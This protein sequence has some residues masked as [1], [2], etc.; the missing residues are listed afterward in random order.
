MVEPRFLRYRR[1]AVD[2]STT[3]VPPDCGAATKR[4]VAKTRVSRP[5]LTTG[6]ALLL[7]I[8][9][10][11]RQI[12]AKL[13]SSISRVR[14]IQAFAIDVDSASRLKVG[15]GF[16][17]TGWSSINLCRFFRDQIARPPTWRSLQPN[18]ASTDARRT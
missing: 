11:T 9:N 16:F 15:E 7:I 4:I 10:C 12:P 3:K 1:S 6:L 8:S 17:A 5:E 14:S 2:L 18:H 13:L